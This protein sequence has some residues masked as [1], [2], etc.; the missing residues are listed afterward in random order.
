MPFSFFCFDLPLFSYSLFYSF[1]FSLF[2]ACFL[3]FSPFFYLTFFPLSFRWRP[4]KIAGTSTSVASLTC[5]GCTSGRPFS[6]KVSTNAGMNLF[7]IT[8][9]CS[10]HLRCFA[11]FA[12]AV[13]IPFFQVFSF[14]FF[15][16]FFPRSCLLFLLLSS[17]LLSSPLLFSLLLC[18]PCSPF[19]S[20]N[21][22]LFPSPL[23]SS[24]FLLFSVF[25]HFPLCCP[26]RLIFLRSVEDANGDEDH[27]HSTEE[28]DETIGSMTE[29]GRK[30]SYTIRLSRKDAKRHAEFYLPRMG[31]KLYKLSK[32]SVDD[33]TAL[34]V[35]LFSW[36]MSDT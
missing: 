21:Y 34:L 35:L 14:S 18:S 16:L 25:P 15:S 1:S 32:F 17:P 36:R 33:C 10:I 30:R 2:F 28:G 8:L 9:Y 3:G 31:D 12:Y 6:P 27:Q 23:F 11:N 26:L 5:R 4:S 19:S 22:R 7:A 29:A 24:I 13:R 20:L